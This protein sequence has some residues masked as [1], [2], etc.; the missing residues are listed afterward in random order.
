L[1]HRVDQVSTLGDVC[2]RLE[3]DVE[4]R[5]RL[6]WFSAF[7]LFCGGLFILSNLFRLLGVNTLKFIT[8]FE[9]PGAFSNR[10]I[11]FKFSLVVNAVWLV[12][13]SLDN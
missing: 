5:F 13:G 4:F 2:I 10:F 9:V 8:I 12:P 3:V 6:A 7:F 11:V 1:L